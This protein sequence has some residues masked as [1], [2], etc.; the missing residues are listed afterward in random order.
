[1]KKSLLIIS[2]MLYIGI[3]FY[4][5]DNLHIK[6]LPRCAWMWFYSYYDNND[7]KCKCY[8]W[9]YMNKWCKKIK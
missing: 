7:K 6:I 8:N 5:R 4:Y 1:M 9:Y 2:L 3:I